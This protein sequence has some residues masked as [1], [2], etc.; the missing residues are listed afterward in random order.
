MTH[1]NE[2]DLMSAKQAVLV[3]YRRP[4]NSRPEEAV[5]IML[6]RAYHRARCIGYF[7]GADLK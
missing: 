5:H 3:G 6:H 4:S 2:L 1:L 7:R